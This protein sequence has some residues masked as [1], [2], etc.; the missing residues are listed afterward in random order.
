[1]Y[2]IDI[3]HKFRKLYAIIDTENHIIMRSLDKDLLAKV[4]FTLNNWQEIVTILK[5]VLKHKPF[6]NYNERTELYNTSKR[7]EESLNK[8]KYRPF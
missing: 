6:P 4:T 1:M 3:I 5:I 2:K 7:L 8:T